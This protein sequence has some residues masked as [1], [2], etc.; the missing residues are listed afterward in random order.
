M[1]YLFSY[2]LG[3]MSSHSVHA[4]FREKTCHRPGTRSATGQNTLLRRLW[5]RD[6]HS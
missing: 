5:L 3:I 6:F 1:S 4:T 2:L